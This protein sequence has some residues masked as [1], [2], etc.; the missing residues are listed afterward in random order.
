[1]GKVTFS[2]FFLDCQISIVW[3]QS[4]LPG[5]EGS[6]LYCPLT[7]PSNGK[8]SATNNTQT[9]DT[10]LKVLVIFDN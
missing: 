10:H 6:L 1:M 5:F 8:N 9:L 3:F 7:W 2:F 4:A